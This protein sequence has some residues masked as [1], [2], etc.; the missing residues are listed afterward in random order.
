MAVTRTPNRIIEG[1]NIQEQIDALPEL[2]YQTRVNPNNPAIW[3][4][5]NPRTGEIVDTG[6]F[7][8][9]GDRGLLAAAAPVIAL[10]AG[11]VGLPFITSLLGGA[12]GL[13]GS[14]LAGAT[15]A[16][17]GAGSQAIAGGSAK[18]ILTAALLGGA[19]SALGSY[20]QN[21]VIDASG[22]TPTQFNDA[23]ETQLI[24]D[25]QRSGLTNVQITQFLENASTADIS[26]LVSAIP[27][28]GATDTLLV[29][30]AGTPITASALTDIISQVPSVVTTAPRTEQVS[31]ETMNAV[32]ALLN[33]N[34]VSPPTVQVVAPRPQE[35]VVPPI[36]IPPVVP[37]VVTPPVVTPTVVTPSPVTPAV[38]VVAPRPVEPVVPPLL[39]PILPPI[40]T[41]VVP[42]TVPP[43]VE[44][45]APRPTDPVVPPLLVPPVTPPITPPVTPPVTPPST[46]PSIVDVIKVI[47]VIPIIDAILNPPTPTTPTTFPV[48]PVP[49]TWTS[50]PPTTV[51]PFTPLPPIDFGNRNLLMGTQWEKFLDP[52]YGT[53]PEPV[54]YSQP[55]NMSYTDLMGILGSKQGMPAKSSL[56]I[57]DIIS[58][59]QNQ[60]GQTPVSTVG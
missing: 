9:G 18:D 52:N 3:E 4:T 44:V 56:S 12:T 24:G 60:Y 58:G 11:T 14:A 55:S 33:N 49:P 39:T 40:V 53:V 27:V 47:S 6:T 45:V 34:L 57:N 25:M 38:E 2:M 41:P 7:A 36:I 31:T 10:A 46:P 17:I 21:G 54:K 48:I 50:P 59:I 37:P 13:T 1:D 22:M 42:P 35:P 29:Q 43:I 30:A 23:I 19:G 16:T 5:Y 26:S 15:G 8:G 20:L 28:T 51:A 32:T